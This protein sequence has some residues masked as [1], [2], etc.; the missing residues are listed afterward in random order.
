MKKHKLLIA[1]SIL[2]LTSLACFSAPQ[3][4][5]LNLNLPQP[6]EATPLPPQPLN[7]AAPLQI[8]DLAAQ[9]D[10]LVSI[11]ERVSPGVVAIQTLTN[12]GSGLGSGFVYD[13]EG[14]IIT[15]YHV[16]EGAKELEVDFP[17]GIKVRGE[18]IGTDLDSD[19]AVIKVNLPPEDLTPVPLGDS[20]QTFVGQT[21]VAIGNPFGL[22]GTMT[23][24]I[25]SAKGRT[26]SSLRQTPEGG[27]YSAG[28][29]LQT[30]ASINPGNSGG[31]LLNLNG[32]V[33]GVNR[34]IRT[35]GTTITGDP[36]NSGVGFA[37]SIN[38]V[39]RVVPSLI[40]QGGYDYPYIGLTAREEL[41]LLEQ[42]SLGLST[43]DGKYIAGAYVIEVVSG[44]PADQAGLRG[45]SLRQITDTG[46][47]AGGDL[48]IGVDGR[49]VRVFGEL[50]S[51]VMT[52]KSPG[53]T[54]SVTILR[55]G[56]EKEV[57]I[58]LDK[59]P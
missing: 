30:D 3:L 35:T 42:E 18:V 46:L 49:P 57:V 56:Q 22:S 45:G 28:D 8:A 31:P 7:T 12:E 9:Q 41:S 2:L 36:I 55:D 11:Y 43:N 44:G 47:P 32:E 24:G 33:I 13:K 52:N 58:T 27:V 1:I 38:I 16:V 6:A 4:S 5:Q 51:Y 23:T 21:V 50:L 39:R 54:I 25:I 53:E 37:V 14:H 19:L 15:N 17:S 40:N 34:A 59:R 48:I 20:E 26:L 10:L 29:I